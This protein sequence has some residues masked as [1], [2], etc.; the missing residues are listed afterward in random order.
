MKKYTPNIGKLYEE[1]GYGLVEIGKTYVS[2]KGTKISVKDIYIDASA[3]MPDV[4]VKYDFETP[5]GQKGEEKNR[6][7]VVIDMIRNS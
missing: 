3:L 7:T 2:K 4:Y 1:V 5:E 6:F